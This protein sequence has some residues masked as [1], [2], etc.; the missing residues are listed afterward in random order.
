[1]E[2]IEEGNDNKKLGKD[3]EE[4]NNDRKRR[5]LSESF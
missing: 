2:T 1:M 3:N 4:D 5:L